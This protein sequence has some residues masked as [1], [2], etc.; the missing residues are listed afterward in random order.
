MNLSAKNL[1]PLNQWLRLSLIIRNLRFVVLGLLAS[2]LILVG[3]CIYLLNRDNLVIVLKEN[4]EQIYA[5]GERK[6]VEVTESH[7]VAL[8]RKFV[9]SR[10]QWSKYNSESM[11]QTLYPQVTRG[12]L[13][14]LEAQIRKSEKFIKEEAIVQY[15]VI[16]D[17]KVLEGHIEVRMDRLISIGRK[18]KV[19][20]SL[21]IQIEMVRGS[22]NK[23]NP[24]G[25]YIN[26]I[27][28][29]E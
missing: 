21:K 2:N 22:S 3:T 6:S 4:E 15:V 29:M 20:R 17:I 24:H 16:Q 11:I 1:V 28:E 5:L 12:L 25:I 18:G 27:K 7:I 10:Y 13:K 19:V 26:A 14:R 9:L 23:W 8:T